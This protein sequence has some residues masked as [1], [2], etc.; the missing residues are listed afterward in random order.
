V[1]FEIDLVRPGG[2]LFPLKEAAASRK[3]LNDAVRPL[4]EHMAGGRPHVV[5]VTEGACRSMAAVAAELADRR[6]D[7]HAGD[8][9]NAFTVCFQAAADMVDRGL[10]LQSED[11]IRQGAVMMELNVRGLCDVLGIPYE[12]AFEVVAS[13]GPVGE[14]LESLGLVKTK[15]Q[16]NG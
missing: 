8:L 16:L 2:V 11:H 12:V 15:E 5:S 13:G 3:A 1:R 4:L 14:L 6:A 7:T 10:Q 9:A